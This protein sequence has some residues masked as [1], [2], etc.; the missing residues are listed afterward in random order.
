MATNHYTPKKKPARKS[1][2][3][4]SKIFIVGLLGLALLAFILQAIPTG[5]RG[6]ASE[7][8]F[9]DMGDLTILKA[10]GTEVATV[11]IE[12]ASTPEQQQR[13]LMWRT[14][15]EEDQGML[16]LMDSLQPQS[17]WMLNTYIPLDIIY[18]DDQ[19][20]IVSIAENTTPKSL[21]PV[22]SIEPAL[23]VLEV[24]GGYA[25]RKGLEVGDRMEW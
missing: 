25:K 24:N 20:R 11:D 4:W 17:F 19:K 23:Y 9:I 2:T 5:N 16:F 8:K 1:K 3:N 22:P 12:I 14:S 21:D 7:P 13:G 18:L 6:G 10:D 15:M